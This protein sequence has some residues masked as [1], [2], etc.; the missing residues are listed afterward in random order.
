MIAESIINLL[1]GVLGAVKP[2]IDEHYA[3]LYTELHKS[4]ISELERILVTS[5]DAD[6]RARLALFCQRLLN[7]AGLAAGDVSGRTIAV[8]VEYFT[9]L[10]EG[11]SRGIAAE[12]LVGKI[13]FKQNT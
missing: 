8:P 3:Q 4:R 11:V 12:Q 6:R 9:N 10:C 1:T 2:S 13:N 7:Q 5:D